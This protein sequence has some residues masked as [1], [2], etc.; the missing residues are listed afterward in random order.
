MYHLTLDVNDDIKDVLDYLDEVA[1][2]WET[3]SRNLH[4]RESKITELRN[5]LQPAPGCLGQ[6]ITEWLKLNYNHQKFGKPTWKKVAESV[7]KLDSRLF[8]RIALDHK[9]KGELLTVNCGLIGFLFIWHQVLAIF[10]P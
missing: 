4:V 9:A 3:I 7:V 6:A 5:S 1:G 8:Q 2:N 10:I